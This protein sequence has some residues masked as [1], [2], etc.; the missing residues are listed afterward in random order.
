MKV[1]KKIGSK[2]RFMEMFKNVNKLNVINENKKE[3][4]VL[5]EGYNKW[6]QKITKSRID[7][8]FDNGKPNGGNSPWG[9]V[10]ESVENELKLTE[11]IIPDAVRLLSQQ[12]NVV[13]LNNKEEY[14]NHIKNQK[15]FSASHS[16]TF[17]SPEEMNMWQ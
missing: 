7:E 6:G 14:L 15:Y 4:K 1:H 11:P 13:E 5:K 10:G 9:E 2:E 16:H 12:P 3:K 8:S 17:Y